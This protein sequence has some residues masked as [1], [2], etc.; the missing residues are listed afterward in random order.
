MCISSEILNEMTLVQEFQTQKG[1]SVAEVLS[2]LRESHQRMGE[3]QVT[4][5]KING[6]IS[7]HFGFSLCLVS[8]R[9]LI[10]QV[11]DVLIEKQTLEVWDT[12][13]RR[14]NILVV[15]QVN[16]TALLKNS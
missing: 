6:I 2:F 3:F 12:N 15:Y 13:I 16:P 7:S 14:K 1:E 10:K 5:A 4:S 9:K 11:V 8:G